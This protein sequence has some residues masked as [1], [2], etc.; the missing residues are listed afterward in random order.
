MVNGIDFWETGD[1]DK[2]YKILGVIQDDRGDSLFQRMG[3]DSSIAKLAKKKGG[4]AVILERSSR[5][6]TGANGMGTY[7]QQYTTLSV[8]KYVD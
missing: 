1:P 5:L 4:D 2:K 7:Y 6:F 8:V 3:K